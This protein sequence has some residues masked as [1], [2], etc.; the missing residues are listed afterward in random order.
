MWLCCCV[1]D[2]LLIVVVEF[3]CVDWWLCV[4]DVVRFDVCVGVLIV[5]IF[6]MLGCCVYFI[7]CC[8]VEWYIVGV[9]VMW[10]CVIEMCVCGK[11]FVVCLCVWRCGVVWDWGEWMCDGMCVWW[12]FVCGGGLFWCVVLCVMWI[13]WGLCGNIVWEIVCV[14]FVC[15]WGML[16]CDCVVGWEDV[17]DF[18]FLGWGAGDGARRRGRRGEMNELEDWWWWMCWKWV[19]NCILIYFIDINMGFFFIFEFVNEGYSDKFAD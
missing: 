2:W 3:C 19:V 15:L 13:C 1:V 18:G 14:D 16:W 9:W 6:E 4:D 10:V 17:E 12:W 8:V 5:N 7:L 11:Y